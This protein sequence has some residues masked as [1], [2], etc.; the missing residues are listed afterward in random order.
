MELGNTGPLAADPPRR[1]PRGCTTV[2][3]GDQGQEVTE[4]EGQQSFCART[5]GSEVKEASGGVLIATEGQVQ[6]AW[7]FLLPFPHSVCYNEHSYFNRRN[8]TWKLLQWRDD[9]TPSIRDQRSAAALPRETQL[10]V[11]P[12]WGGKGNW[13]LVGALSHEPKGGGFHSGQGPA[14]GTQWT[15]LSLSSSLSH[16]NKNINWGLVGDK[17]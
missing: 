14:G 7:I 16:C 13:A 10:L 9:R 4:P 1:G 5:A 8:T 12:P 2:P 11:T 15:F 6:T 3:R 17:D